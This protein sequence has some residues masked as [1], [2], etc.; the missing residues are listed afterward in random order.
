[1]YTWLKGVDGLK[2]KALE[3]GAVLKIFHT[4]QA[5]FAIKTCSRL[6]FSYNLIGELLYIAINYLYPPK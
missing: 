5:H 1:M 2:I 6:I 3:L 4:F